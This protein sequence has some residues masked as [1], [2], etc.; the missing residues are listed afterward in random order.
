MTSAEIRIA[1]LKALAS[2]APETESMPVDAAVPLR[3]QFDL[4]SMDFLNFM[5]A[6]HKSLSV[7]IAERDYTQLATLDGCVRFVESAQRKVT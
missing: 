5:V 1:I 4:D 6:V 2:V 3:E 7:E